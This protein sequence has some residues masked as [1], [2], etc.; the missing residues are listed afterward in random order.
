MPFDEFIRTNLIEVYARNMA[1][2]R[3]NVFRVYLDPI[4][5]SVAGDG[6]I[7]TLEENDGLS[8]NP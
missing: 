8:S 5:A 1:E 3:Q 6:K 2:H 4:V 7:T